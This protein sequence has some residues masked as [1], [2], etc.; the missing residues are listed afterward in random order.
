MDRKPIADKVIVLG[1]DGMDPR[2]TQKYLRMGLLPNVQ[3]YI[4]KGACREDL[5]MLGGH[6]TVTPSMWTTLATG[7]YANVHG[8]TAYYLSG[9]DIGTVEYGFDSRK[10]MAEPAW[11][12]TAEA[13]LKTLVFH[14]PGSAWPPTSDNPNLM[15][16]DGTSPGCVAMSVAQVDGDVMVTASEEIKELTFKEKLK[17]EANA[18]CIITDLNLDE[19]IDIEFDAEARTGNG[20]AN[21]NFIA[22]KSQM[23]TM[24]TE[25]PMDTLASPIKP[26]TGW[27]AAPADAKEFTVLMSGGLIRRPALI[28]KNE[29]GIFDRVAIYKN[30]KEVEP[31]VTCPLGK[32]MVEVFDE[33]LRGDKKFEKVNRNFKLLRL[34][35]DGSSL[36]LHVSPGMD[37]TVDSVYHPQRLFKEI[38]ENVG[39]PP[40]MTV[41]GCQS[42]LYITECMSSS[43]DVIADWHAKAILHLIESEDLD[44]VFSHFHNIDIQDH[45]FI[46]HAAAGRPD[47]RVS[48]EQVDKWLQQLYVQTDNYLGQ[49]MHLLDEG[50]TIIITSDH[51]QVASKY[52]QPML[53]D[54]NGV[55]TPIMEELGF[56]ATLKDETGKVIGIDWANTRAVMQREGHVYVN[57]KGRDPRG[58]VDPA[59]KWELEEEIMTAL[60]GLRHPES[61]HRMV[62]I[63]LR[64]KDAIMLGQG[65]PNAGDICVWMAEGYNFDHCD[66]YATGWGENETSVSPLFIGVGKGFKE[67]FKTDRMIRQIDVAPTVAYLCGVR[68]P[69]QCEG[70]PVYQ[71]FEEVI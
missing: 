34:A 48:V 38:A 18:A 64:N 67:G 20:N 22:R 42:D 61:G 39:Y 59:D 46:K 70:A 58:I 47:N 5:M 27:A 14:W 29:N 19:T 1:I 57:L 10:C 45:Q 32:V 16:V 41:L 69:A 15:V 9:K 4:D 17:G 43:W 56:T 7:A 40:P 49:F 60:Y 51:G 50:W 31:M 26:A 35:E 37:A 44:V 24:M 55:C 66:L 65:G 2:L 28:L 52:E 25:M 36:L 63:A 23:T 54:M 12:A 68:T 33:A 62:A 30:K 13:G 53:M 6:P 21:E 11:N 3:K 71:I 8:I